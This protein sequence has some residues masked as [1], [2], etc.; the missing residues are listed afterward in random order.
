MD[1]IFTRMGVDKLALAL[2]TASVKN[3][4]IAENIANVDTPG[5]KAKDLKFFNVMNEYLGNGKKLPLARTD[6]KH[7]PTAMSKIDP[8]EYVYDQNNPSVRNDGNDVNQDYEMS[9][10]AENSIRYQ[11]FSQMTAGKF[12][13]LKEILQSR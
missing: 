13:K 3:D 9:Q 4:V 2:N 11:M 7:L 12:T 5:Y 6:E 10:M 1:G 8:S